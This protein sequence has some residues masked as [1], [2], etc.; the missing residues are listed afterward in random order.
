MNYQLCNALIYYIFCSSVW[1][2]MPLSF[3]VV[4]LCSVCGAVMFAYY[5][6]CDPKALKKITNS[7]QVRL[8]MRFEH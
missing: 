1:L 5:E 3:F 7:D 2:A 6:G 8:W 4:S